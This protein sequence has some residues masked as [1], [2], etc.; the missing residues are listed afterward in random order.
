[1]MVWRFANVFLL[2]K[3][4]QIWQVAGLNGSQVQWLLDSS[5]FLQNY[6]QIVFI[7]FVLIFV[8]LETRWPAW[9]RYRRTVVACVTL[10]FHTAVLVGITAIAALVLLA[11]PMLM[12]SKKAGALPEPS[13]E[14]V[15]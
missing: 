6:G 3:L 1:M 9:P 14:R 2:P 4:E 13:A 10:F 8:F 7:A 11:A 12:K 5:R 15:K